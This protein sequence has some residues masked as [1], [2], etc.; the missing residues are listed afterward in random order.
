MD[1]LFG[2]FTSDALYVDF[3]Q[4]CL[5]ARLRLQS[6]VCEGA[7][8]AGAGELGPRLVSSRL[9]SSRLVSLRLGGRG[10]LVAYQVM[11]L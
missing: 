9:V 7:G 10:G 3:I 1:A 5:G 11:G 8:G 2:V 4:V 6:A